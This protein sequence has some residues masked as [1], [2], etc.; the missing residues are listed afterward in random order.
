MNQI[1]FWMKLMWETKK[2]KENAEFKILNELKWK[3]KLLCSVEIM[4]NLKDKH[5]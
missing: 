4:E 5:L 2:K 3:K 1:Y